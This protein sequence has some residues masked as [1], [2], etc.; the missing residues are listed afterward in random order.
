MTYTIAISGRMILACAPDG[1]PAELARRLEMVLPG[2]IGMRT[3]I[4]SQLVTV[5]G[6]TLFP[7]DVTAFRAGAVD[8]WHARPGALNGFAD[9][10]G[11]RV[12]VAARLGGRKPWGNRL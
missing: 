3:R 5:T 9:A 1:Q 7:D 12:T 8:L 11:R 2:D 6:V 10:E 4:E